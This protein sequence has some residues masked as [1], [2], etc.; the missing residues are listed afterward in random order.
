[1]PLLLLLPGSGTTNT[2]TSPYTLHSPPSSH[3]P[4][5]RLTSVHLASPSTPTLALS[6]TTSSGRRSVSSQ[7]AQRR[8]RGRSQDSLAAWWK[9]PSPLPLPSPRTKVAASYGHLMVS[10]LPAPPRKTCSVTSI[11]ARNTRNT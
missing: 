11:S 5:P 2:T 1:M 8:D 4:S 10:A 7:D 3:A 9:G 6:S